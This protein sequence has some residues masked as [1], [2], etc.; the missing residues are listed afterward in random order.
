[1]ALG[2]SRFANGDHQERLSRIEPLPVVAV[3]DAVADHETE[4][5]Q[6]QDHDEGKEEMN[7]G[8]LADCFR[9]ERG[10]SQGFVAFKIAGGPAGIAPRGLCLNA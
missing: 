4:H 5:A 3:A 1:M 7:C 10:H 8:R 2:R 6:E 9:V